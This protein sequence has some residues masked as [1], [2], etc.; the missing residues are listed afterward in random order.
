MALVAAFRRM[1][2]GTGSPH[3]TTVDCGW[4]SFEAGGR[5]LLQ[6]DTFGSD[7]REIKGK[8]SQTLQLDENRAD[9]LVKIIRSTFPDLE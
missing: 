6:L 7:D 2:D 4:K 1:P 5:R 8:I 3:P 9:D